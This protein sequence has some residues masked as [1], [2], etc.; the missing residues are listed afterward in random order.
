MTFDRQGSGLTLI[1][2]GLGVFFVFEGVGKLAWLINADALNGQLAGWL[3]GALPLN[4]WYLERVAIPGAWAFARLVVV[5]ELGGGLALVLGFW[6]KLV[7]ALVFLMV[8]NFHFASGALFHYTFLANPYGLP[9]L[10]PLVGL[11][12]GAVRLP[13]SLRK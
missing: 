12:I 6:T 4:R 11:A 8:L 13:L 7:A 1:R 9:V 2:I 10:G 3:S 5:G